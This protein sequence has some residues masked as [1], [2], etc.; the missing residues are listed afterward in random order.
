MRDALEGNNSSCTLT[1]TH[2]AQLSSSLSA[3]KI[4]VPSI[5]GNAQKVERSSPV[6][7]Q[8][9]GNTI[10][11]TGVNLEGTRQFLLYMISLFISCHWVHSFNK[12]ALHTFSWLFL[13][14]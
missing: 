4:K 1:G 13:G 5:L 14:W 3:A 12:M 6:Y 2:L 10:L 8:L 11:V 9:F 7:E